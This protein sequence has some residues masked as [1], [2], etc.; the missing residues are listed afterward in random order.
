MIELLGIGGCIIWENGRAIK[1]GRRQ[2]KAIEAL[3]DQDG[4]PKKGLS[5]KKPSV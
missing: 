1:Q 4:A 3:Q 2:G 5:T